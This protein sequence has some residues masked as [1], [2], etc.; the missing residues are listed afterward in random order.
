MFNAFLLVPNKK[1]D[2]EMIVCFLSATSL[3]PAALWNFKF[4][5]LEAIVVSLA[6]VMRLKLNRKLWIKFLLQ[7]QLSNSK[8]NPNKFY[9]KFFFLMIRENF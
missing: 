9:L 2:N 4:K 5:Q 1:G 7:K 6:L 3:T 8:N